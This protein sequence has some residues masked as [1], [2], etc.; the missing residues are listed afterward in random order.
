MFSIIFILNIIDMCVWMKLDLKLLFLLKTCNRIGAMVLERVDESYCLLK[1][2]NTMNMTVCFV[3]FSKQAAVILWFN[4]FDIF[5]NNCL[6]NVNTVLLTVNQH[7]FACLNF[8]RD[9]Q[10]PLR[11]EYY[12]PRTNP[13]ISG[14]F[15][16]Y[17]LHLDRKFYL[18]RNSKSVVNCR[19]ESSRIE[20]GLQDMSYNILIYLCTCTQF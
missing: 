15:Q 16:N 12:S 6:A 5:D 11:C 13:R 8:S 14:Y 17:I 1:L 9:S 7:L 20:L 18:R 19:K 4:I 2:S 3:Y 10:K